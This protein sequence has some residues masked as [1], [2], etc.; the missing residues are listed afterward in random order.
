MEL[1]IVI[2][3]I[4]IMT[5]AGFVSMSSSRTNT[6]LQA[7]QR[8]VASVIKL[9]Q[10]YALQG[11]VAPDGAVP[12]GYG[13][14]FTG[15]S[16]YEI[17]YNTNTNANITCDEYNKA[18]A[19]RQ[20]NGDDSHIFQSLSLNNGVTLSSPVLVDT[21]IYFTVPGGNIYNKNGA[22]YEGQIFI[23]DLSGNQK[24]ITINSGGG[25]TESP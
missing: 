13:F 17:F 19:N 7:A 1:L 23:F 18:V 6:K 12:C 16:S 8:E 21:E 15:S 2:A 11:K 22:A 14:W 4:G 25:I 20:R 3:I 5:V 9:T 24:T 10:S